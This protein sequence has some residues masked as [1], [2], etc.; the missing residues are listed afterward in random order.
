MIRKSQIDPHSSIIINQ[1]PISNLR[2]SMFIFKRNSVS[3]CLCVET[4]R[5]LLDHNPPLK[6][7]VGRIVVVVEPA[8]PCRIQVP[9]FSPL[10]RTQQSDLVQLRAISVVRVRIRRHKVR[11]AVVVDEQHAR[12]R[13]HGD[14]GG[15]RAARR[16]RN[17][18]AGR[19]SAA[20]VTRS[21]G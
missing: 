12:A 11:P 16:Q 5:R 10:S 17:R 4:E 1:S 9:R 18:C 7:R 19:W 14:G 6:P 20:R 8:R 2:S 13:R 15:V 21:A 3:L